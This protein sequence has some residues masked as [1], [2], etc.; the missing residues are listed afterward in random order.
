MEP[1]AS[2]VFDPVEHS[3][4]DEQ[5]TL[6]RLVVPRPID[7]GVG[8]GPGRDVVACAALFRRTV[9]ESVLELSRVSWDNHVT[10]TLG[11]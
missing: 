4:T 11:R 1:P 10:G 5:S 9:P 7:D 8:Q 3:A 6:S 2:I